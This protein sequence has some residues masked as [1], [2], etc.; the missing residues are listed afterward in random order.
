[1]AVEI[2]GLGSVI[3]AAPA[4][5]AIRVREVSVTISAWRIEID[6][7]RGH[8]WITLAEHGGSWYRGDGVFLGWPQPRLQAA[9]QALLPAP[10]KAELDFPQ[11]G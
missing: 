2:E 4:R 1:M 5:T 10:E 7:P 11:L 6:S 8:G 3:P 9:W